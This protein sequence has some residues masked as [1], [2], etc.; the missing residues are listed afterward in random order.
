MSMWG[1]AVAEWWKW[2]G[3]KGPLPGPRSR[4]VLGGAL[5]VMAVVAVAVSLILSSSPTGQV[6]GGRRPA[7]VSA[8]QVPFTSP[9]V[10]DPTAT[11][12]T[13]PPSTPSTGSRVK[14]GAGGQ[15]NLSASHPAH[16]PVPGSVFLVSQVQH[17]R[18]GV[19]SQAASAGG[20]RHGHLRRHQ[21][22]ARLR[23]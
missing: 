10:T 2:L 1:E 17:R 21:R 8:S 11:T 4:M 6:G 12:T 9:V 20:R 19:G 13:P 5:G 22:P 18:P 3:D 16:R 7:T 15:H 14:G 23:A